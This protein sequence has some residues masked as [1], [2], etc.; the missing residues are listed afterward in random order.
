MR[1]PFP[2][3]SFELIGFDFGSPVDVVVGIKRLWEVGRLGRVIIAC[4][5]CRDA[6]GIEL[7]EPATVEYCQQDWTVLF[8]VL[9]HV[10]CY[11]AHYDGCLVFSKGPM[12]NDE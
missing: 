10:D 12:E 1:I 2:E 8:L 4:K 7:N 6:C 9:A 11:A 5:R 3:S